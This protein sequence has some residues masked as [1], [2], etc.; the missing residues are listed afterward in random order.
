[1]IWMRT[2]FIVIEVLDNGNDREQFGQGKAAW[3]ADKSKTEHVH[4]HF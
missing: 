3:P 1:M 2:R 4:G